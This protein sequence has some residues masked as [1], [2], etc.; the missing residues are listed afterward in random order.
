[1]T[2]RIAYEQEEC[3]EEENCERSLLKLPKVYRPEE[4]V[5]NDKIKLET[6]KMNAMQK[7]ESPREVK[8][9]MPIEQSESKLDVNLFNNMPTPHQAGHEMS[10]P[11]KTIDLCRTAH[12]EIPVPSRKILGKSISK[13]HNMSKLHI[14]Q[15]K[16]LGP[17]LVRRVNTTR[18][19]KGKIPSIHRSPPKP[20]DRQGRL[21]VKV[22]KMILSQMHAKED[23]VNYKPP[24]KKRIGIRNPEMGDLPY[25]VPKPKP[26]PKFTT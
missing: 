24:S 16:V 17:K 20:P 1:M 19:V 15:R 14:R 13:L 22:S 8:L 25:V 12:F 11:N 2:V 18:L 26:P 3:I 9:G 5:H 10:L 23:I 4:S 7:S 21:N 6:P